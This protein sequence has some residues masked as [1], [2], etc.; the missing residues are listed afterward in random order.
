MFKIVIGKSQIKCFQICLFLSS[1]D[2]LLKAM[3]IETSER[4]KKYEKILV[5][6]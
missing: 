3:T 4:N 5:F 6:V 2:D 1:E